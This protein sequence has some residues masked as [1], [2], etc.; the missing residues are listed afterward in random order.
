MNLYYS[1]SNFD[2]I[3]LML[4]GFYPLLYNELLYHWLIENRALDHQ[5]LVHFFELLYLFLNLLSLLFCYLYILFS[6]VIVYILLDISI[7]HIKYFHPL[8]GI[9]LFLYYFINLLNYTIMRIQII[10]LSVVLFILILSHRLYLLYIS[11][12]SL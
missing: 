4:I 10:L 12:L 8:L 2:Y 7:V 5:I 3:L 9:L 1:Y 6:Y 11:L